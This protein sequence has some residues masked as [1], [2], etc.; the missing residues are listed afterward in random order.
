MDT[1]S[2]AA[3][4]K[5][6]FA[7][8]TGG[9]GELRFLTVAYTAGA[10]VTIPR[11]LGAAS[12]FSLISTGTSANIMLDPATGIASGTAA[13]AHG[14]MQNL[15]VTE[16]LGGAS[17]VRPFALYSPPSVPAAPTCLKYNAGNGLVRW[18]ITP[19]DTGGLP[20]TGYKLYLSTAAGAETLYGPVVPDANGVVVVSGLINGVVYYAKATAINAVGESALS[21]EANASPIDFDI[22]IMP[23]V[24]PIAATAVYPTVNVGDPIYVDM[25]GGGIQIKSNVAGTPDPTKVR[26]TITRHGYDSTRTQ[27]AYS[28]VMYGVGV[29]RNP[30]PNDSTPMQLVANRFIVALPRQIHDTDLVTDVTL[31]AGYLPGLDQQSFGAAERLDLQNGLIGFPYAPSPS[32]I[33]N[34][35]YDR[36]DATGRRIEVAVGNPYAR[37]GQQVAAVDIWV[38]D[39]AGNAGPVTTVTSMSRSQYTPASGYVTPQDTPAPVYGGT[40]YATGLTDGLGRIFYKVYP[41]A[42]PVYNSKTMGTTETWP[43]KNEPTDGLPIAIDLAGKHTPIYAWIN[44][45]G[46]TGASAAVQTG[47]ADPGAAGSYATPAAAAAALKAYNNANRGHNDLSGGVIMLRDVAGSV[48]GANAGAYSTR[49]VPFS[50]QTTYTSGLTPLVIRAASGAASQLCRW[51]GIQSDGT[52]ISAGNKAVANKIRWQGVYFDSTG[53]SGSDHIAI[54]AIGEVTSKP[55]NAALVV[56]IFEGCIERG[57][58]AGGTSP[59]LYRPGFRYDLRHDALYTGTQNSSMTMGSSVN[60]AGMVSSLGSKY[61]LGIGT[62]A[63][64]PRILAGFYTKNVN[65]DTTPWTSA[66]HPN[67]KNYLWFAGEAHAQSMS[68]QILGAAQPNDYPV[69]GFWLAQVLVR[70]VT[71]GSLPAMRLGADGA[72]VRMTNFVIQHADVV[73]QRTNYFYND[74]GYW[75]V[76]KQGCIQ[77]SVLVSTNN[78]RDAFPAPETPASSSEG[79]YSA[80]LA[81][82]EGQIIYDGSSTYYQA[83]AD[84]PAGTALTNTAYFYA[85]PTS[86]NTTS[87]FKQPRRLGAMRFACGINSRDNVFQRTEDNS[88]APSSASWYGEFPWANTTYNTAPTYV[89]DTSAIFDGANFTGGTISDDGDYTPTGAAQLNKIGAGK[90]VLPFD[91]HGRARLNDGTGAAGCRERAG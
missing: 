65:I 43:T 30:Y 78:K 76:R 20:I 91:L 35:P 10:L 74:Q 64:R 56:Q 63:L 7:T 1:K 49:G 5:K 83:R 51:R 38:E 54:D 6:G 60:Y 59:C 87:F 11:L 47:A 75:A 36:I 55:T 26:V 52:V 81:Y 82:S 25:I 32:G 34:Q 29:M 48:A 27:V 8:G 9:A 40:V 37:N 62:N 85:I 14:T 42:G 24:Y 58:S 50:S 15:L 80:T 66:G 18:Q 69:D 28:E 41:W 70:A 12:V 45:D 3:G 13:I 86:L 61:V 71:P 16:T 23:D 77:G 19:N 84:A 73:G 57:N 39:S 46:T 22:S 79:T 67:L 88:T 17:L 90:A 72:K 44:Q 4:R 68:N 33:L 21:N 2:Y 89:R 31:L 53:L